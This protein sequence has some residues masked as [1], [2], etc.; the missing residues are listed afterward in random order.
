MDE[1]G[2]GALCGPVSVGVVMIDAHTP[3]V[4]RGVRDSKLLTPERREELRPRV[5]EWALAHAVGHASSEE[6][7]GVGIIAA[8]RMAAWR[9]LD[10][11]PMVPDHVLLDGNHNYL[12]PPVQE[13]LFLS[14]SADL[15]RDIPVTTMV[16]G[17]LKCAGVA[18][19]SILAKTARD[20]LMLDLAAYFPDYGW[21]ENKGYSAPEHLAALTRLGPTPHHRVSWNLPTS[22]D[23]LAPIGESG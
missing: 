17:D 19:A 7:D 21:A 1:V 9:A 14:E 22:R 3:P 18:A 10:A 16:K 15:A 12:R 23:G 6:I 20:A 5:Q 13:S 11:L 8:L 2:R 4:P